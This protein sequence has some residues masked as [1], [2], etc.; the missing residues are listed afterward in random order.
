MIE[1]ITEISKAQLLSEAQSMF[2]QQYRLVTSTCVD[3]GEGNLDVLYHFDKDAQLKNFRIKAKRGEEIPSISSVYLCAVL[4]ENEMKELF[5]LNVTG[6]AIDYGG[7]ML[8]TPEE[9][10]NPQSKIS[11]VQKGEN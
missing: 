9:L 2:S 1:N 3:L 7:H 4:I 6:I 11:I 5:G 8:L 10:K